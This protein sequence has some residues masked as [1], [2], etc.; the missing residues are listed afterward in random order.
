MPNYDYVC[1][2]CG[3]TFEVFQSM[4]DPHLVDCLDESCTGR[5]KRKLGTG[6][7]IIFK[8][9]GFYATDYRSS[10]Y[11]EGAKKDSAAA[12]PAKSEAAPAKAAPA[13]GGASAA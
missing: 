3:K 7:G 4:N 9:S 2:G 13:T 5:L 12:A 10:S 8:G 1:N 11:Q 6:A